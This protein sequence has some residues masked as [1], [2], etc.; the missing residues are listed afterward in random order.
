MM[1]KNASERCTAEQAYRE[2]ITYKFKEN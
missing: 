2:F 1:K